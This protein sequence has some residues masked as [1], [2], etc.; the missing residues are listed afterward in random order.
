MSVFD[1][2]VGQ[3]RAV[4][5][6][7]HTVST[8]GAMTH[9]WLVTGPPGSGRSVAARAFAAALQCET[10]GDPG[11]G[12]CQ[13]C[14]TAM[15]GS[16]PDVTV[17]AT[18]ETF[19][20]V[21][22]ARELAVLAQTR[23]SV[24]R[25]RVIVVEDADRLNE[26]AADALL[27]S[28]E[29]PPPRTVWVLCAP[30]QDDLIITVRSRC[31]HLRLGTPAVDAV[32]DLLV[33]RDGI[34]PAMAHFAARAAQSH[35][36]IAKR[37]ATDEHARARRR[38][39]IS[40]PLTLTGLGA[41]LRAAQ[42]LVDEA[43]AG[44]ESV[45]SDRA[46]EERRALLE[47]LGADPSARTQPPAVRAHLRDLEAR[48]KR[49]AKRQQHDSID[50]AL[51]DLASMYRDALMVATGSPVDLV[52]ATEPDQVERLARAFSPEG[53]LGAL[54]TIGLARQ[55]LVANG[56]PLLVLEA[57]MIGLILPTGPAS[58]PAGRPR[59]RTVARG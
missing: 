35:I 18:S 52:N 49:E 24:G 51:T 21:A 54:E 8:P 2:L 53:L 44:A 39:I 13:A 1:E 4:E 23:P 31:R 25:W 22:Q 26:P 20:K 3:E 29:E 16:H 43:G 55:R 48:Q 40:L 6:L 58:G 10:P 12:T 57:M 47:Q 34:D 37:L 42:D 9:A 46:A 41:A 45:S 56:A 15:A 30:A 14:R 50:A 27:K 59:P 33:R 28:L 17:V 5:T 7:R 38:E 36:G 32:A 11:C 19:I